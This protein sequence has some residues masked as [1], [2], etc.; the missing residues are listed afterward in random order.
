MSR[1]ESILKQAGCASI[2]NEKSKR[3]SEDMRGADKPNTKHVC[4]P[5]LSEKQAM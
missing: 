4:F 1:N 3:V 2:K 5:A